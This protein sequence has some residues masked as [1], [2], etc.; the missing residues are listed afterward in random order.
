[1]HQDENNCKKV[2]LSKPTDIEAPLRFKFKK[3]SFNQRGK[4]KA[5]GLF[6]NS[7]HWLSVAGDPSL[8]R[9]RILLYHN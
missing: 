1:M 8:R 2:Y 3:T 5:I 4:I 9:G 6:G 7:N